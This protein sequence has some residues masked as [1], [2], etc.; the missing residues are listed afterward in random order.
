MIT[1]SNGTF[2]PDASPFMQRPWTMGYAGIGVNQSRDGKTLVV[3][4][5]PQANVQTDN[6]QD[7]QGN[8]GPT[9]SQGPTGPASA[10]PGPT[11]IQGPTGSQGIQ[12]PTGPAS[13]VP[14]PTG[15]RG[16]TGPGGTGPTGPRGPTGLPSTVPGPTGSQGPTGNQGPTGPASTVPGPQG[17]TGP[18]GSFVKT[19]TGN[20]IELACI[21]GTRPWF[22]HIQKTG[23]DIPHEFTNAVIGEMLKFPSSDGRHELCFAVRH[24][25]PDWFMPPSNEKQRLH[26]VKWWGNE[27]LAP[28]Q[29]GPSA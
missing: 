22:F 3:G 17:P 29:R 2:H 8:A 1:T 26:S 9:G 7:Q 20:I 10:V 12:G 27:Y 21:E 5:L 28:D 14:G 13:T 4:T 6:L 24:E 18:K 16:P 11:G 23:E 15:A 19:R 25:F